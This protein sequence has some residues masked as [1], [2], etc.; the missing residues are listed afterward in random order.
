MN[1]SRAA[2]TPDWFES[3]DFVDLPGIATPSH[4][5]AREQNT[6]LGDYSCH[7]ADRHLINDKKNKPDNRSN[8]KN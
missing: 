8:G 7:E 2:R 5:L 1:L 3:T 4:C 6:Y